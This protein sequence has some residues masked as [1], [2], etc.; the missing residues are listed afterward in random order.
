MEGVNTCL[1]GGKDI[2]PNFKYTKGH[3]LFFKIDKGVLIYSP[4][5]YRHLKLAN[6]GQMTKIGQLEF[7]ISLE[8]SI[9]K[10]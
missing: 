1:L 8:P 5:S 6:F 2:D 7:G 4:G 10:I 9:L 3:I